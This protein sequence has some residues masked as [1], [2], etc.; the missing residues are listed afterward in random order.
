MGVRKGGGGLGCGG[1][2][3]ERDIFTPPPNRVFVKNKKTNPVTKLIGPT[4]GQEEGEGQTG[5]DRG[6]GE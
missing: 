5:G 3:R 4:G 2:G 1:G 6:C